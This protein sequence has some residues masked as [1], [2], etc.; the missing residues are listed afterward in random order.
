MHWEPLEPKKI[1][2]RL[3]QMMSCLY[4][5]N[6]LLIAGESLHALLSRLSSIPGNN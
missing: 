4:A 3:S 6:P 2:Q 5:Q 1:L